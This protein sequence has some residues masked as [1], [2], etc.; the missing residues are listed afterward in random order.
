MPKKAK[1]ETED[2]EDEEEEEEED[3]KVAFNYAIWSVSQLKEACSFF[4]LPSS[5]VKADLVQRLTEHANKP[6]A[7]ALPITFEELNKKKV[8]ELRELCFESSLDSNGVKTVLVQ[9][10]VNNVKPAAVKPQVDLSGE[11]KFV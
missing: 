11:E 8:A 4:N 3:E 7:V 5:G 2:A 1:E 9:R 6:K 10:L